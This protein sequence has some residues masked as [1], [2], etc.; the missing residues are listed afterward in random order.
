MLTFKNIETDVDYESLG[1]LES[2][3]MH[4]VK[5]LGVKAFVSKYKS[6]IVSIEQNWG[7]LDFCFL[8][9]LLG[10][11]DKSFTFDFYVKLDKYILDPYTYYAVV[12]QGRRYLILWA[13]I[14]S[15]KSFRNRGFLYSE[16][17]EAF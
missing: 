7:K 5:S 1:L 17:G 3:L 13:Y 16:I 11:L 8:L 2:Q 6:N 10:Y 9:A 12:K 15:L 4:E 14:R